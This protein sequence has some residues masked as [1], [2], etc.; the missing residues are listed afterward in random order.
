MSWGVAG[1]TRGT[2]GARGAGESTSPGARARAAGGAIAGGAGRGHESVGRGGDRA[3]GPGWRGASEGGFVS[4][5]VDSAAP[6]SGGA[7]VAPRGASDAGRRGRDCDG[8][9][10]GSDRAS[11]GYDDDDGG[12]SADGDGDVCSVVDAGGRKWIVPSEHTDDTVSVARSGWGPSYADA[13]TLAVTA[14]VA[15]RG[16]LAGTAW[17]AADG[18]VV[19]QSGNAVRDFADA[20][21]LAPVGTLGDARLG[22]PENAIFALPPPPAAFVFDEV[23]PRFTGADSH[24]APIAPSDVSFDDVAAATADSGWGGAAAAG[25]AASATTA[26]SYVDLMVRQSDPSTA[27]S[28]SAPVTTSAYVGTSRV[29]ASTVAP[30]AIHTRAAAAAGRRLAT[31]SPARGCGG[32]RQHS[33]DSV[34]SAASCASDHTAALRGL[35]QRIDTVLLQYAPDEPVAPKAAVR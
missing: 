14:G 12:V 23:S 30:P 2:A 21:D 26:A 11:G 4:R 20:N 1:K 7:R 19:T 16:M 27:P 18:S 29:D 35:L 34:G 15:G 3:G 8:G 24:G 31:E 13:T 25:D 22:L 10:S 6:L 17:S 9:D 32:R 5:G 33:V 28:A